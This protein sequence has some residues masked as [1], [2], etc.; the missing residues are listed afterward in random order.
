M[1]ILE[2]CLWQITKESRLAWDSEPTGS[3][4]AI[5]ENY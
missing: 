2:I 4:S 5:T 3:A 1:T